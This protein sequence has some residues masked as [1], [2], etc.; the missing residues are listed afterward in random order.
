MAC[1]PHWCLYAHKWKGVRLFT[2]KNSQEPTRTDTNSPEPTITIF[3]VICNKM[4]KTTSFNIL[5]IN[6]CILVVLRLTFC[7]FMY[8]G[9]QILLTDK[10]VLC[11]MRQSSKL[12]VVDNALVEQFGKFGRKL[13]KA[14]L[15]S[16][17]KT[18]SNSF[19][20]IYPREELPRLS[21]SCL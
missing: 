10:Q 21:F 4:F 18:F 16:R 14:W 7:P 11:N 1:G 9:R 8:Q 3:L 13:F 20:Y 17:S 5:H 6:K 19:F 15:I 12:I 2:D